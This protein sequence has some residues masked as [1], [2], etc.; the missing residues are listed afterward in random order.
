MA[1]E[2]EKRISK[3]IKSLNHLY[4]TMS[5]EEYTELI[6]SLIEDYDT[7]ISHKENL[8]KIYNKYK[9]V[10]KDEEDKK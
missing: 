5:K 7:S 8:D 4:K 6:D 3:L 1:T 9:D 2:E 10:I